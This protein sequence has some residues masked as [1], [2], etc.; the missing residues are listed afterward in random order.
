MIAIIENNVGEKILGTLLETY[1]GWNVYRCDREPVTGL[2][3]A[4]RFGVWLSGGSLERVRRMI[5]VKI[6]DE[7]ERRE[8]Q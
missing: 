7:K 6:Q 3:R 2:F 4:S 8:N 1:R 5:D